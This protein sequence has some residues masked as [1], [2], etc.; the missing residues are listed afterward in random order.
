[1]SADE[2]IRAI[3]RRFGWSG[4]PLLARVYYWAESDLLSV[5]GDAH[6]NHVGAIRGLLPDGVSLIGSDYCREAPDVRGVAR[7]D[8]RMQAGK[9]AACVALEYLRAAGKR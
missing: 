5:Y 7:L 1:M 6:R 9:T 4:S 8:E 3:T 2:A